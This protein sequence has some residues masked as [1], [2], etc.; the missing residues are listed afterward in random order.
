MSFEEYQ[1]LLEKGILPQERE[2]GFVRRDSLKSADNINKGNTMF[3]K[4]PDLLH[5]S[6][7]F[8]LSK[9]DGKM[10]FDKRKERECYDEEKEDFANNFNKKHNFK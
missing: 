4:H 9:I 3:G 7:K 2:L 1:A 8:L 6:I 10:D 5:K